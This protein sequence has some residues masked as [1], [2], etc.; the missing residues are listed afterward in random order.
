MK[1][2]KPILE[3]MYGKTVSDWLP[4]SVEGAIEMKKE[5][6]LNEL[7]LNKL[8]KINKNFKKIFVDKKR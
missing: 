8:K 3:Q 2:D 1:S 6:K 4:W 7:K 5:I